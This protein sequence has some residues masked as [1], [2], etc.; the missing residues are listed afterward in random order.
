MTTIFK[1]IPD[2]KEAF[3]ERMKTVTKRS[4]AKRKKE[5]RTKRHPNQKINY[6]G[7]ET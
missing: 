7:R 6:F 1:S 5:G 4:W 2:E 3:K